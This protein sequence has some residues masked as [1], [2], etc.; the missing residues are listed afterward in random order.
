M[1]ENL[2]RNRTQELERGLT[3]F[4]PHRDELLITKSGLLARSHASQGEAWS[5]ALGLKLAVASELRD[6]PGGD[7]VVILDDV[8]A[9]LDPGR[10]ARLVEFVK[11]FQQV[12]VT[13]AD[14]DATPELIWDARFSISGGEVSRD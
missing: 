9:V 13:A 2:H 1:R 5:L 8:F 7:P 12:L 3:L 6:R 11:G 10:R 14:P 4:G